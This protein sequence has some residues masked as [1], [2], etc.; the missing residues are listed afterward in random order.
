MRV[1]KIRHLGM[2]GLSNIKFD[3]TGNKIL[4]G[5]KDNTVKRLEVVAK[6]IADDIGNKKIIKEMDTASG[7]DRWA[8]VYEK[9]GNPMIN[10]D[11]LVFGEEF[12]FNVKGKSVIDLGCG[13][14]RHSIKFAEK[15]ACVTALDISSGMLKEALKKSGSE[16]VKFTCYDLSDKLPV[17]D[18]ILILS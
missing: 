11:E 5:E 3:V 14:G 6:N 17:P 7:Y 16:K 8:P 18:E 15:G 4:A 2:R 9:D 12:T 10:L 13:T 1:V